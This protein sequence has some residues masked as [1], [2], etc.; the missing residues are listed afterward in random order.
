MLNTI[1]KNNVDKVL[2]D[3]LL[4]ARLL[5]QRKWLV[6][7]LTICFVWCLSFFL[8]SS[9]MLKSKMSL[10]LE[11]SHVCISITVSAKLEITH[12]KT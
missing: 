3:S 6:N 7:F 2:L 1:F 11:A 4:H 12:I 9:H 5:F 8:C 10:M